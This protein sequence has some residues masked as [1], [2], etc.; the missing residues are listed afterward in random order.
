MVSAGASKLGKTSIIFIAPGVKVNARYYRE[1]VLAEMLPEMDALSGGDY[2]FM[3][4]GARAHTARVNIEYLNQ[5]CPEY[6]PLT[7]GH[8]IAQI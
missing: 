4:D 7:T 5:N 1:A 6:I 8:L 3:Q 2:V